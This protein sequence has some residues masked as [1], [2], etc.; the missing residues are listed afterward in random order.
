MYNFD[1]NYKLINPRNSINFKH[2]KHEEN[3]TD[4]QHNKIT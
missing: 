4:L 2:K 1:E 3:N